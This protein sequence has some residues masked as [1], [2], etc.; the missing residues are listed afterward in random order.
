MTI[1]TAMEHQNLLGR[2]SRPPQITAG[3]CTDPTSALFFSVGTDILDNKC[4]WNVNIALENAT[5]EQRKVLD[6]HYGKKDPQSEAK[7]KEI[8]N[9]KNID[10]EGRFKAYEAESHRM[11][12]GMIDALHEKEGL[13]KQ[14]FIEFLNKVYKRTK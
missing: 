13:K 6:D 10:V 4:S 11:L 1:L 5:P 2:V 9:A 12:M 3:P 7:V 14:V 8:F